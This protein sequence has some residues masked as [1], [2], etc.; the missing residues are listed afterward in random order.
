MKKSFAQIFH[1][2]LLLS[3]ALLSLAVSTV[4]AQTST[5]TTVPVVAIQAS[6]AS[7]TEGGDSGQFR[8]VRDGA[9]NMA[10][11]VYCVISGTASNGV[12]FATLPNFISIPAGVR[13]VEL[14]VISVNDTNVESPETVTVTLTY[15]PTLPPI[16]Y[17]IGP[18]SN[19]T[20]T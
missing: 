3:S 2:S 19:A 8:V 1:S 11:S 6:D 12:D 4:Q 14:P 15:P 17:I 5:N 9:T 16:N 7:A 13:A 18:H 10:L 20:V